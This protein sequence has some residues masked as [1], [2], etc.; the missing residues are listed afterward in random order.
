MK[1]KD[2]FSQKLKPFLKELPPVVRKKIGDRFVLFPVEG[3]GACGPRSFAAWI[4][5][6]PTLG[7]YLARNMN[8]QFVKHWNYWRDKFDYP[9]VR[10]IGI[11]KQKKCENE[12]ELL[13]F[14]N[15]S[16]DGAYMWRG[17]EDFCLVA[18]VFQ[19][20]ITIII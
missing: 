2:K 16:E 8:A 1:K 9:F 20:K 19:L 3:D 14:F 10:D 6:D 15:N 11:G 18:N 13:E 12:E 17:Q 4:F 7:P 5:Q